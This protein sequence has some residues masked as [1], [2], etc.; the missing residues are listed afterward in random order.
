MK[1]RSM[2]VRAPPCPNICL[3][4]IQSSLKTTIMSYQNNIPDY[5]KLRQSSVDPNKLV[6]D[7]GDFVKKVSDN[8]YNVNG[9]HCNSLSS[10]ANKVSQWGK[11]QG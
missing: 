3:H 10:A 8:H 4:N 2:Q 9:N 6:N 5:L 11:K 1:P 7:R